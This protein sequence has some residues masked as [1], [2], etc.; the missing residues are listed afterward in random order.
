MDTYENES[1]AAMSDRF[2]AAR[3]QRAHNRVVRR[4]QRTA[5]PML[6]ASILAL[7]VMIAIPVDAMGGANYETLAIG[8]LMFALPC[9]VFAIDILLGA[10]RGDFDDEDLSRRSR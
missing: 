3:R 7:V 5:M 1:Y 2:E 10:R 8:V 4:Y 6:V 9:G